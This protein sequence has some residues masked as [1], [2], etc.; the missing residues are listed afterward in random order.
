M[1][2]ASPEQ[3]REYRH[4]RKI[5]FLIELSVVPIAP[6]VGMTLF[7][8]FTDHGGWAKFVAISGF[9][10]VFAGGQVA[11]RAYFRCP[12]CHHPLPRGPRQVRPGDLFKGQCHDCGTDF[13]DDINK[14]R[15]GN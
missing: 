11:R 9:L 5:A 14:P 8:C 7:A 1:A 10:L 15:D 4:R 13:A 3:I 12:V 6:I 2:K